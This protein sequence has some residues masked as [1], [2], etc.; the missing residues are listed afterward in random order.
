[1]AVNGIAE[2]EERK[3]LHTRVKKQSLSDY[4]QQD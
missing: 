3:Y 2:R 4:A 1:M